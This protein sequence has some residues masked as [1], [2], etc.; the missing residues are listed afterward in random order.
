MSIKKYKPNYKKIENFNLLNF[1]NSEFKNYFI[2]EDVQ[3]IG[4]IKSK[5]YWDSIFCLYFPTKK[6]YDTS[7]VNRVAPYNYLINSCDHIFIDFYSRHLNKII[8]TY[9]ETK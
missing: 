6:I 4:S 8:K 9:K 7:G 1:I 2:T 3:G 5:F